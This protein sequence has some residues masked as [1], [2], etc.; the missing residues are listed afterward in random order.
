[1]NE[2]GKVEEILAELGKKI[3]HLIDETKRAGNNVSE[4]AEKKINDL[5]AQKERLEDD[6]KNYSSES[7]EKWERA[8]I[9]LNEAATE[10][11][12]AFE[13]MFTKS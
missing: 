10:I 6:F 8:K 7:G 1:M 12:R 11:R 13:A 5:K 3:D 4:E 9:H 2:Q